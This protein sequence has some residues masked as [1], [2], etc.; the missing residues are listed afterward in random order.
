MRLAA[1]LESIDWS[2]EAM[3][4]VKEAIQAAMQFVAET[5][6]EGTLASLRLEEV[7][8]SPDDACWYIT[9]SLVRGMGAG[10]MAAALGVDS[11]ARDYKTV[12]VDAQTG[13]VKSVKIR[14]L[15]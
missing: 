3:I 2:I 10:A 13:T 15:A 5:F 9:V 1:A 4:T 8:P 14:Q 11:K 12:T 6:G 7:E